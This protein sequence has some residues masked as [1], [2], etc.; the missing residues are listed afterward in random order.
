M[1]TTV[2]EPISAKLR[3]DEKST[4]IDICD[5]IGT[6]PSNAI[7][8]FVSAFNKR[9]GFPFDL[10]NPYGYNQETLAAMADAAQKT[11]LSGPFNSPE[12]MWE[13]I[14]AEPEDE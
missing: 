6:T 3:S 9:G 1:N 5:S 13:S 8:M 7:R 2:M 14:L 4:F 10:S 12:E 11:N